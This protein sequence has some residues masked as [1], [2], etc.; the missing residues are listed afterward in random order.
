MPSGSERRER[1]PIRFDGVWKRFRLGT[2]HDSLRDL[3]PAALGRLAGAGRV[4]RD[5]GP[6]ELWAVRDVSF[7]VAPGEVLGIIGPNGAGK[8][9]VLKLLTRVLRPTRG[10]IA[11]SGRVGA[12]IEVSAGFHPDLTGRENVYLQGAIMGMRTREIARK[13]DAIIEFAGIAGFV[14]TPVKRYSSGMHARLGFAI[15]AHLEPDVLVTDEVLAVGDFA[16]QARAFAR[17]GEIAAGGVPVVVVSHQL[18]RVATLCNRALVLDRGS[19]VH[20]GTAP[21]CVAWYTSQAAHAGEDAGGSGPVR[22][23]ALAVEAPAVP[24][25]SR[26]RFQVR[27]EVLDAGRLDGVEAVGVRVRSTATGEH[28]SITSSARCGVAITAP[29]LFV[30]EADLQLNLPAGVYLIEVH[31]YHAREGRQLQQSLTA[32]VTVTEG[33][34]FTGRVQLNARMRLVPGSEAP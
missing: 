12:L 9:T 33:P 31:P 32:G 6:R 2:A 25:G 29:G 7:A 8:S 34:S 1:A 3:L 26:L 28:V 19:V 4:A 23:L 11:T 20:T 22:L 24:S 5:P 10:R 27:G 16:F 18:D 14:D 13:F 15:A 21:D 30:L 17:L